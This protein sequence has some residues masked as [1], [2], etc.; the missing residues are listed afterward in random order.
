MTKRATIIGALLITSTITGAAWAANSLDL[1]E[2][3]RHEH[4]ADRTRQDDAL[5]GRDGQPL[6]VA[7]NDRKHRRHGE[8]HDRHHDD[9][10][11]SDGDDGHDGRRA[12][13]QRQADPNDPAKAVPDNGLFNGKVRPK[14]EVQ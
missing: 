3:L 1:G 4:R 14:V 9:D 6:T 5:R 13:A 7:D 8:R 11:D 12:G 2:G 10:D